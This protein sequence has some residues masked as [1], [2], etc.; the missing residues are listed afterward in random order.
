MWDDRVKMRLR[1]GRYQMQPSLKIEKW[2]YM[3]TGC[4][5]EWNF[6]SRD[7]CILLYHSHRERDVCFIWHYYC[8]ISSGF[9]AWLD[10][11]LSIGTDRQTDGGRE[12]PLLDWT[13]PRGFLWPTRRPLTRV[14]FKGWKLS[15]EHSKRFSRVYIFI[16]HIVKHMRNPP[17]YKNVKVLRNLL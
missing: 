17:K 16:V 14:H 3:Q 4:E 7:M 8:C 2:K 5:I 10:F 13:S 1:N 12:F 15:S 9:L 6:G 11:F